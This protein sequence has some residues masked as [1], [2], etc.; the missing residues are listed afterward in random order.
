M[1]AN[2]QLNAEIQSGIDALGAGKSLNASAVY[3]EAR[4]RI[5]T[6]ETSNS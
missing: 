2:E 4:K 3:A 1:I 5:G 6:I